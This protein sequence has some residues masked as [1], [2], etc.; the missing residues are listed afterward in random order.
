MKKI[1]AKTIVILG[2]LLLS[3]ASI[4]AL[5][6]YRLFNP[7]TPQTISDV[8]LPPP[9][10]SSEVDL[11]VDEER[12]PQIPSNP[13]ESS[14]SLE[15]TNHDVEY[16]QSL[17]E[18]MEDLQPLEPIE[19]SFEN[20]IE[21]LEEL[22]ALLLAHIEP[23]GGSYSIY[24]KNLNTNEY[25]LINHR[26]QNAA[27]LIKL[28]NFAYAFEKNNNGS[29][30]FTPPIEQWLYHSIVISCNNSYNHLLTAI[31][32]GSLIQGALDS[33]AFAHSQGFEDTIVGGSL[34]P[35]YFQIVGFSNVYTSTLD[36][37]HLLENIYRGTMVNEEASRQMLDILLAQ[38]RLN[39]I[40]AGLPEGTITAS[41]T[42]EFGGLEHDAAIVFTDYANY[43]I[44]IMTENAFSAIHNIQEISR[45]VYDYFT[46]S[47]PTIW[48]FP[49]GVGLEE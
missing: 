44:A 15:E 31:G 34:H 37:G 13:S 7:P 6:G 10:S 43:V 18:N 40:P 16:V 35:S 21:G 49:Y 19:F 17:E 20:G 33:T 39:K 42:G 2:I 1:N 48:R 23:L 26:P 28:F 29:L 27:S 47:S 25:L 14:S 24:V 8:Q 5:V 36:V 45:L 38:Q 3:A 46:L 30:E 11:A 9:A 32:Y 4:T 12:E 22:A 41:K